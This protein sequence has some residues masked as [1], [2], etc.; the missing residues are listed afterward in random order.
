MDH[1]KFRFNDDI[2]WRIEL[3]QYTEDKK[4]WQVKVTDYEVKNI[5]TF[6]KQKSIRQIERLKLT[7]L[8]G[9]S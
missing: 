4:C 5:D 9:K 2:F 3:I 6:N 8:I 1:M 7:N